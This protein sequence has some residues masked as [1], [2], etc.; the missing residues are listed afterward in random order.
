[1]PDAAVADIAPTPSKTSASRSPSRDAAKIAG[2]HRLDDFVVGPSNELAFAAIRRLIDE[3][4]AQT[5]PLFIH[6]G[7]GLGKTHL[8]QGLCR[9]MLEAQPRAN[10][11]YATG[12]QFT[13]EFLTAIRT[14][15]TEAF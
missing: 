4:P 2:R 9:H 12:E 10:V 6:G 7:V 13:N 3:A 5:G 11:L 8:L 1:G 15:Q 14:G